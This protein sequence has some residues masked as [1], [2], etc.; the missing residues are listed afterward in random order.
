MSEEESHPPS[1][2]LHAKRKLVH[3]RSTFA[4]TMLH[5][6]IA[7]T[8]VGLMLYCAFTNMNTQQA[9]MVS[10]ENNHK[11]MKEIQQLKS[12]TTAMVTDMMTELKELR[13]AHEVQEVRL[14]EARATI[15]RLKEVITVLN[16]SKAAKA[17]VDE[18]IKNQKQLD[19]EKVDRTEFEVLSANVTSLRE[20]SSQADEEIKELVR[21][22][23]DTV[24]ADVQSLIKATDKHRDRLDDVE[25]NLQ[26]HQSSVKQQLSEISSSTS[27]LSSDISQNRY[28]I[29]GFES[30][31]PEQNNNPTLWNVISNTFG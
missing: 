27:S 29:Q 26:R 23:L 4:G 12:N 22:G 19:S 10:S 2:W 30:N 13:A 28:D 8:V 3:W 11:L 31:I 16:T 24:S 1:I 9:I 18:L 21:T 7:V 14:E 15:S 5:V 25:K 20:T 17:T 6:L